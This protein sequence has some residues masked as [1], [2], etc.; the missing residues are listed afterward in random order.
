MADLRQHVIVQYM[1]TSVCAPHPSRVLDLQ[2]TQ[3]WEAK[4]WVKLMSP[5]VSF[6]MR[7]MSRAAVISAETHAKMAACVRDLQQTYARF[8]R[9]G[10]AAAHLQL[11]DKLKELDR[12][13]SVLQ[14]IILKI[15]AQAHIS[16]MPHCP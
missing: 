1:L 2:A 5:V 11:G 4:S 12:C 7:V 6:L 3:S 15:I 9:T 14:M 10:G 13:S 16:I 8:E